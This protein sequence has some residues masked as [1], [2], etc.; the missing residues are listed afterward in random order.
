MDEKIYTHLRTA[1][2]TSATVKVADSFS[3]FLK[4]NGLDALDDHT[5][6]TEDFGSPYY[7]SEQIIGCV[8][9][10]L[11]TPGSRAHSKQVAEM[12]RQISEKYKRGALVLTT[13]YRTMDD[14]FSGMESFYKE[15]EIGLFRQTQQISRTDLVEQFKEDFSSVLIGTESFWEGVDVPG[16]AL[17]VLLIGKLPFAVPTDPIVEANTKAVEEEG[18]N[19]FID[20]T[21]PEAIIQFRQGF[22]RL[23]RSSSDAGVVIIADPRV[24]TKFYG[25]YIA[26]SLP[27]ELQA[28]QS[29]DELFGLL[30]NWFRRN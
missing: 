24:A 7:L 8:T 16:E 1:V 30:D 21:L 10:F 23:I 15:M 4:R 28:C 17:E 27:I 9:T 13:S 25:R 19:G 12:V 18:G 20:Y 11:D 26:D 5:V 3:Y 6:I 2:F 29:E 22:G 14:I